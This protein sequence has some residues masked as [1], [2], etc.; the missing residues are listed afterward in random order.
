M[1]SR[2]RALAGSSDLRR[3]SRRSLLQALAAQALT[4]GAAWGQTRVHGA[5]RPLAPG[6]VTDEWP[7][8]LGPSHNAVS[9]ET[10]LSRVLPP[11]LVWEFAKGT[12]Y[13]SPCI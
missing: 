5:P 13:A 4:V 8:F 1:T 9:R 7:A 10:R 3:M 2:T 6:A 12:G 11:P